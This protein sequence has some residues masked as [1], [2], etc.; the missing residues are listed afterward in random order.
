MYLT[1]LLHPGLRVR[2]YP[3]ADRQ[4]KAEELEAAFGRGVDGTTRRKQ[5]DLEGD[6]TRAAEGE[7]GSEG[8]GSSEGPKPAL[9]D[10]IRRYGS[11][12]RGRDNENDRG[13]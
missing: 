8:R 7:K 5:V 6:F 3:F 9:E 2:V 13:R 4:R 12:R 10:K 1:A 11:K